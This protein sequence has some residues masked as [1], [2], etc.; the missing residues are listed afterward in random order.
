MRI[1]VILLL[2]ANLALF[3]LMRLDSGPAGEGQ[4]L[5]EQVQPDKLRILS[6]QQ[7]AALGPAKVASMS[8]V[9]VE[10][11]PLSEAERTRALTELAPLSLGNLVTTKRVDASGFFVS[12]PGFASQAAADKRVAELRARGFNDVATVDLGKG[13]YVVSL[14]VFRTEATAN[15]RADAVAQQGFAGARVVPRSGGVQQAI[16]VFRDPPQPAVAKLR[17]LAP[18]FAGT[19]IR[20]GGCERTG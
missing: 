20:V 13:Q 8:D 18:A 11:G 6:P 9:C 2:L 5:A 7:V 14:G 19:E 1:V 3:A 17:E 10:W 15:G 12:L 4:R 16:L